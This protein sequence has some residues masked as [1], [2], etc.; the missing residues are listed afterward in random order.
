VAASTALGIPTVL[1]R[2]VLL[3]PLGPGRLGER[4]LGQL[5][6]LP[7]DGKLFLVE[8]IP[9]RWTADTESRRRLTDETLQLLRSQPATLAS[10]FEVGA[11]GDVHFVAYELQR[12]LY[13][14][15]PR[16]SA[17][18]LSAAL[19]ALLDARP[20]PA[21][22]PRIE[23]T[24]LALAGR[25]EPIPPSAIELQ[26]VDREEAPTQRRPPRPSPWSWARATRKR[27]LVLAGVAG[28]ATGIVLVFGY[29]VLS[30]TPTGPPQASVRLAG[31]ETASD[32]TSS[33]AAPTP[34]QVE[35]RYR[36]VRLEYEEFKRTFGPRL[37]PS[38]RR[39]V[40]AFAQP[41]TKTKR[42]GALLDDLRRDMARVRAGGG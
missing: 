28:L 21:G 11:V 26:V 23:G 5:G 17:E 3:A 27:A 31:K 39:I 6:D 41:G 13:G 19:R 29:G 22:A 2:Y 20:T 15:D 25:F 4:F 16:I 1:G 10:V 8:Q 42:L 14:R 36:A 7:G 24:S 38:W 9:A 35:A 32:G 37:E 40:A 34:A 12:N 33:A 30:D 18:R